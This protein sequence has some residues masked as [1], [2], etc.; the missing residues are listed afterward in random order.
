MPKKRTKHFGRKA[1]KQGQRKV[2][3]YQKLREDLQLNGEVP[4]TP[5]GAVSSR[6]VVDPSV[7][8]TQALPALIGQAIRRGWAVPDEK[9]PGLVD[10]LVGV[11]EDPEASQVAK[12]FAFNALVKG[13]Q[14]QHESDQDFIRL[15]QVVQM[16]RCAL[17]A[18]RANVTDQEVLRAVTDD[19]LRLMPPPSSQP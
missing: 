2:T 6:E 12:V 4:T 3:R 10:E 14:I 18:I 11:V 1:R 13:D 8:G 19:L 15:D 7:Q 5:E 9:K 16:W 17:E